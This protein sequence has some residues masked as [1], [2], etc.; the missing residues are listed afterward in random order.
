L[1]KLKIPTSLV[2]FL[3]ILF[4]N[5][6]KAYAESVVISPRLEGQVGGTLLKK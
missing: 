4:F 6:S 2:L 5:F 3:I 1:R